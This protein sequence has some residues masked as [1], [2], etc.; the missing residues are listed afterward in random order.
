MAVSPDGSHRKAE[1][2]SVLLLCA[3]TLLVLL[4]SWD[5]RE[6]FWQAPDSVS[7]QLREVPFLLSKLRVSSELCCGVAGRNSMVDLTKSGLALYC[8]QEFLVKAGCYYFFSLKLELSVLQSARFWETVLEIKDELGRKVAR[9]LNP[10]VHLK[11]WQE[12]PEIYQ[13][14]P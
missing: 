2:I 13:P 6:D 9:I 8:T 3:K 14:T 5:W 11:W 1:I 10:M 4:I 7:L 12:A